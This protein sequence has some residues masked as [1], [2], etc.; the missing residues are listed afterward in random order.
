MPS[1]MWNEG[2]ARMVASFIG[3][4]LGTTNPPND[5]YITDMNLIVVMKDLA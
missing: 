4:Y 1:E 2:E 3:T 5:G